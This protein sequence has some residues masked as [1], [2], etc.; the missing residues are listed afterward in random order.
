MK[1]SD[2]KNI[3]TPSRI[4]I[5][6]GDMTSDEMDDILEQWINQSPEGPMHDRR[7][8]MEHIAR[9]H[10]VDVDICRRAIIEAIKAL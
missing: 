9:Q 7:D 3:R 8:T 1:V 10:Y 4:R 6:R 2:P 5:A